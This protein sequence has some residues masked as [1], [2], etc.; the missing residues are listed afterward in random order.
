MAAYWCYKLKEFHLPVIT[1]F[2]CSLMMT[3]CSVATAQVHDLQLKSRVSEQNNDSVSFDVMLLE[4]VE[5]IANVKR[6]P[7]QIKADKIV[8]NVAGSINSTGLSVIEILRKAPGVRIVGEDNIMLNGKSGLLLYLDGN[9]INLKGKDLADFLSS[10]PSS[11]I[12][13]IEII[14]NPSSKY[15]ASGNAGIISV[16]TMKN[17]N[18]GF[19]GNASLNSAFSNYMP[20]YSSALNLNYRSKALNIYGN[21]NYFHNDN[22]FRMD[23]FRRQEVRN[24]PVTFDQ[25]YENKST[26]EGHDYKGGIDFFLSA[27]STVGVMVEGNTGN[28]S[29]LLNANTY[30]SGANNHLDSLL[31]AKNDIRRNNNRNTY[32][33][34]YNYN[35]TLGREFNVTG[36]Y[37]KFNKYSDSHQQNIYLNPQG[38]ETSK[39]IYYNQ[40]ATNIDIVSA[41]INYKQRLWNGYL[42]TG[43]KYSRVKS[44]NDLQYFN[45]ITGTFIPDTN[46]TNQFLY[47]EDIAA[48][49]LNYNFTLQSWSFQ[50][51]VRSEY[52]SSKGELESLVNVLKQSNDTIYF[53]LFPNIMIT[54]AIN[55]QHSLCLIYNRRIDRPAY[56]DLNP[57]EFVMDELSYV[58]GNPFLRPQ[59]EDN[60]K[61]SY[62]YRQRYSTSISYA[63]THD[64]ILNYRDTLAGGKTFATP[65][66][67]TSMR[68]FSADLSA[69]LNVTDW[70]EAYCGL[71]GFYQEIKGIGKNTSA[72]LS[73]KTW[74]LHANNTFNLPYKWS[75]ELSGYYNAAFLD[76]PAIVSPQWSLDAGIQKKLLKDAMV[77]KLSISDLFNSLEYRL[78]RDFGGLYYRSRSKWESQQVRLTINYKLGNKKLK[79]PDN[80]DNGLKDFKNR[81]K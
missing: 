61:L 45:Q 53:N 16:K 27:K 47:K 11:N 6:P 8:V 77:V 25:K 67:V 44:E 70:W 43:M 10:M 78:K 2:V 3:F 60:L 26:A 24:N 66:N 40:T 1:C 30:I 49:Y 22:R 59:F 5:V 55:K 12:E 56:Q 17:T 51:G 75:A 71:N 57:F 69:R 79:D 14:L 21:Y 28:G 54:Y 74:S 32:T 65:I 41:M 4:G 62:I 39:A 35:D 63:N 81:I 58:K 76:V 50:L 29:A 34:N 73:Q 9:L 18:L 68:T 33:L 48:A 36:N 42:E 37:G 64:F 72:G 19:N 15:D 38:D 46:R 80:R 31:T 13:S 20:K 52:T 7:I 23:Y